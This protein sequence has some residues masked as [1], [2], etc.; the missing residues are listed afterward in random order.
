MN[1][2]I[3]LTCPAVLRVNDDASHFQLGEKWLES[4]Y[5]LEK[6]ENLAFL[7]VSENICVTHCLF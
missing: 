7:L 6:E 1:W 5:A 3:C 4:A 2:V